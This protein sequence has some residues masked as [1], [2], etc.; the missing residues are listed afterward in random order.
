MLTIC[1]RKQIERYLSVDAQLDELKLL[2]PGFPIQ[3]KIATHAEEI[4]SVLSCYD[5]NVIQE[6]LH[7]FWGLPNL[8][9]CGQAIGSF[10]WP[11]PLSP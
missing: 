3:L 6:T 7:P 1:L 5:R 9:R 8:D 10:A 4:R 11:F 2:Q